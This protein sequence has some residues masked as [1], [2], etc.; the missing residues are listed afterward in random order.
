MSLR[1]RFLMALGL[2]GGLFL[3]AATI[4]IF[5]RMESAMVHQLQKQF[6]IDTEFRLNNLNHKFSELTEHIRSIANLPMFNS[7]RFNQLTLNQ[8]ALKNDIRQLELYIYDSIKQNSELS[9]VT[10]INNQGAEVFQ[11]DRSGIKRHLS[12]K[13]QDKTV[14]RMLAL[15]NNE[16]R[17]EQENINNKTQY[18]AWWIP[19]YISSNRLE[20]ILHLTVNYK[21][22]EDSIRALSTSD[23]EMV[24]MTDAEGS[25]LLKSSNISNCNSIDDSSW[26]MSKDIDLPGLSWNVT[27]SV[28]PDVFLNEINNISTII[29]AV[30]FPI[31]AIVGFILSIV[32]SNNIISSIRKLVDGARIMGRS[33]G[34]S[35]IHLD[36]NDELGE[37]AKEM[38]RSARLIDNNRKQLEKRNIEIEEKAR[39]NLQAIMDHSPAVIYVKDTDGHYTFTNQ[40]FIDLFHVERQVILNK[41]D[42]EIFPHDIAAELQ[43][44]DQAVITAADALEYEE[45]LPHDDG[46]HNYISIKF[47]LFNEAGDIYAICSI[48]TDI[49]EFKRQNDKL[50]RSQKMDALGKLTGGIAHDYNNM[51]GI[52]LG[53]NELLENELRGKPNLTKYTHEIQR[54]GERSSKLTHK[55]LA[56]SRKKSSDLE[57]LNINKILREDQNMLE[58]TLTARIT[59]AFD[60]ADDLW[61][62]YLDS[63]DLEDAIVN[64]SIN[65]MHAIKDSG[66]LTFKTLNETLDKQ[67]AKAL[68]VSPGNY[69]KL[70]VIDTG[71]GIDP[72]IVDKIFDPFFTSKGEKGTGLGLSQVYGFVESSDGHIT[73][74]SEPDQ[75]TCF[76]LYF[77]QYLDKSE[78]A[79]VREGNIEDISG[80]ESI[81]IVDDEISLLNLTSEIVSNQGYRVFRAHGAR[82]ALEI[83]ENE[84]IDLLI[85]DIIMPDVDGYQLAVMVKEKYPRVKIQ[86]VSGY[87]DDRHL[88]MIDDNLHKNL[89][90]KPFHSDVLL[91]RVRKLLG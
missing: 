82:Q 27:L 29:F 51:L 86:L 19:V 70:S 45:T 36:R 60:F 13:S 25:V 41:T 38:N 81:L 88:G 69:V 73:V 42:Y 48:S 58:K 79:P 8:A 23:S 21:H 50:R 87:S 71:C 66:N 43:S 16:F 68:G 89:I 3:L 57:S 44:N 56:F 59:L 12:D 28:H 4:L 5:N 30:I 14:R 62:V 46:P 77:P 55:L 91:Q 39:R 83:L 61:N 75:G 24:C 78:Q 84:S 54:A 6:H 33:D 90:Y 35:T 22:F 32:F 1:T 34:L 31:L 47:P 9:Q 72:S 17:I 15:K 64:M 40:K 65:A 67:D 37:L 85:S 53:Y 2:G 49:T 10:Y 26:S 20:G 7:I 74:Q 18:L 76:S 80:N 52:M 63:N 11:V